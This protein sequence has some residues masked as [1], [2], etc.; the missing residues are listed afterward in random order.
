MRYVFW[1]ANVIATAVLALVPAARG[2]EPK[3]E[4]PAKSDT[5]KTS[6]KDK[7]A[8]KEKKPVVEK[9]TGKLLHADSG[10]RQ[11]VMQVKFAAPR[12]NPVV[13]QKLED[14]KLQLTTAL[15]KRDAPTIL[16]T[17]AEIANNQSNLYMREGPIEFVADDNMKIRTLHLPLE[18]D[19]KGKPRRLTQKE[20]NERKGSDP[21]LRGYE[22]DFDNL[23]A[24]QTVEV[25]YEKPVGQPTK[26]RPGTDS[27]A[28]KQKE[29]H[30]AL[31]VVIISDK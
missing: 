16:R 30:K 8:G 3:S 15:Q 2:Q 17:R 23:K 13:A 25:Q 4:T 21:R 22:A 19:E 12:I 11:F 26:S 24:G 1:S 9:I 29:Q 27:D 6:K 20:I 28:A 5:A 10:Q 7:P 31:M 14:L 18:Y